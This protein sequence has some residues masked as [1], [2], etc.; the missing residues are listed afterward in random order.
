M[1]KYVWVLEM[2]EYDSYV[3]GVYKDVQTYI[4]QHQE[5]TW[6]FDED[7]VCWTAYERIIEGRHNYP[8][9]LLSLTKAKV[10]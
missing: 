1:D 7:N 4:N 2:D 8:K 6:S 3:G 10:Q 9:Y 5:Y